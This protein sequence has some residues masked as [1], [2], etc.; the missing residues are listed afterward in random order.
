MLVS[1]NNTGIAFKQTKPANKTN[2]NGQNVKK[3]FLLATAICSLLTPDNPML[4]PNAINIIHDNPAVVESVLRLKYG[5][6]IGS[7]HFNSRIEKCV[8][9]ESNKPNECYFTITNDD[10]KDTLTARVNNYGEM[11]MKVNK[12]DANNNRKVTEPVVI[13]INEFALEVQNAIYNPPEAP[14]CGNQPNITSWDMDVKVGD[15]Y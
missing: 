15:D 9:P 12:R 5:I 2:I 3:G 11:T 8:D 13:N 6:N 1:R 7:T 14:P 10:T 4:T